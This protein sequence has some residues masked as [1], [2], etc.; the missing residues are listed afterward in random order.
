MNIS[1]SHK[2]RLQELAGIDVSNFDGF[3]KEEYE[4]QLRRLGIEKF[5]ELVGRTV[6]YTKPVYGEHK[7]IKWLP[8]RG[9]YLLFTAGQRVLSNPFHIIP[10]PEKTDK[11]T[12]SELKW[13]IE[14]L[15]HEEIPI[16]IDIKNISVD[17]SGNLIVAFDLITKD[18]KDYYGRVDVEVSY[19]DVV[20]G[21][22]IDKE[23]TIS[24][25]LKSEGEQK[26]IK[27]SEGNVGG[28]WDHHAPFLTDPYGTTKEDFRYMK[29]IVERI[30]LDNI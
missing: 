7:V 21:L 17:E 24:W 16:K 2:K 9:E 18:H 6:Y 23:N 29:K 25:H 11:E 15:C 8:D 12:E 14:K 20:L 3:T 5:E 30:V 27:S 26:I 22:S 10:I 19:K 13:V 4:S 1:E 28:K